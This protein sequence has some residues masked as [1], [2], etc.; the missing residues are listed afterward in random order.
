MHAFMSYQ[1]ADRH[2]AAKVRDILNL[3]HGDIFPAS[4]NRCKTP[5]WF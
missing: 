1:T 4:C 3:A 5:Y 2:V